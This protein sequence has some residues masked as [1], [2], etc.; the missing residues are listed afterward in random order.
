MEREGVKQLTDALPCCLDCA[1]G[2]V[3]D[4][5]EVGSMYEK[6]SQLDKFKELAREPDA[7]EYEAHWENRLRKLAKSS[8]RPTISS[9][10]DPAVSAG[11]SRRRSY[12]TRSNRLAGVGGEQ[13]MTRM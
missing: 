1:F 13:R 2:C 8:R 7:D 12:R 10:I 11:T 4:I 5:G 3:A 6:Q 9:R